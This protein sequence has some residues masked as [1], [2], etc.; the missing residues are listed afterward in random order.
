M[1]P[2]DYNTRYKYPLVVALHGISNRVY[3][4][5][6]LAE[7]NFRNRYKAFVLVPIAPKRAFWETPD[8]ED[9]SLPQFIP[10]P[11]HMPHVMH[12]IN[13]LQERYN[14]DRNKIYLTGHSMGGQGVFG[15]LQNYPGTFAAAHGTRK[16]RVT[17]K[18]RSGLSMATMMDKFRLNIPAKPPQPLNNAARMPNIPSCPI[19]AMAAGVR[20]IRIKVLGTGYFPIQNSLKIKRAT[21]P[22]WKTG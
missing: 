4:A 12:T 3:A 1:K 14:I 18:H 13:T 9:Y 5:E 2:Q 7:G 20:F 22:H 11:D 15:A 6:Y 8:N 19:P 16:K 17:Y 21:R 10:Y